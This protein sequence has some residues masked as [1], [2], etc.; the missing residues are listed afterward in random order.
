MPS[1]NRAAAGH[2]GISEAGLIAEL[3]EGADPAALDRNFPCRKLPEMPL[4]M[5][6]MGKKRALVTGRTRIYVLV[7]AC[8]KEERNI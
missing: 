4:A 7:N 2:G 8:S 3:E 6:G 1:G 5:C